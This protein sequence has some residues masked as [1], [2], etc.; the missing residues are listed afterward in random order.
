MASASVA[1]GLDPKHGGLF[2]PGAKRQVVHM[3]LPPW[4]GWR[5]RSEPARV[6]RWIEETLVQPVGVGAGQPMRVAPFQRVMLRRIC[7]SLATVISIPAGNGKTTFMAAVGLE[8]LCRG[9]DFVEIDVLA[10]KEDQARRLIHTTIH[11]LECVPTLL[12]LFEFYKSEAVLEYKP[13]GSTMR[14]HAARLSSV[15]GLNSTLAL[16]DEVGMV[17]PA[18]V[19]SMIARLGKRP[20]QRVVGFGTPGFEGDNMLEV[21]RVLAHSGELP[22]GMEFIEYA[23]DAGCSIDDEKQ[24]R[25]AN[26]ALE[27]G[28]LLAESLPLKAAIMP[29]HE[30]R[31]YHL[32][33]PVESSGPWLPHGAWDRCVQADPPPDGARVVLGVWGSYRRQIAVVGCTLDGAVFFGWQAAHPSDEELAGVLRRAAEQWDVLEVVHKPHIRLRLMAELADEDLPVVA[34]PADR[35]TDV[36]ST[37]AL[38]AAVSESEIAH[39]HDPGLAEQVARLTAKVDRQGLPRLVESTEPDV[40]GAFAARAAWWRARALAEEPA[41]DLVIW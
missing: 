41:G 11:M 2:R 15:Q 12:P 26:P 29:E 10:T 37:A 8:R 20:A 24:W 16:I 1:V 36:E 13:T 19:T 18:F 38:Y 39:D 21:V 32:G 17:D 25:K 22:A 40:C 5:W 9:D 14:A 30:F 3:D 33:Q 4:H 31:A 7:D 23:A 6:I 28:F 34:W 35:A 27:A